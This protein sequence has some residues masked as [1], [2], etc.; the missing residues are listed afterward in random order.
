MF[1]GV[2]EAIEGSQGQ[3][4]ESPVET[5]DGVENNAD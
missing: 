4:V 2:D 5:E 1:W 3:I